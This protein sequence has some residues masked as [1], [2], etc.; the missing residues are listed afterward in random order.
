MTTAI[1]SM[2]V[3]ER[4]QF[5]DNIIVLDICEFCDKIEAKIRKFRTTLGKGRNTL[6]KTSVER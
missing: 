4:W 5:L 3:K 1:K 6:R 2:D